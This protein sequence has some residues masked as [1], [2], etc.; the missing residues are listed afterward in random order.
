MHT[1]SLSREYVFNNNL[2]PVAPEPY[3]YFLKHAN[4]NRLPSDLTQ[5]FT[6]LPALCFVLKQP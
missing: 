5:V 4:Y 1:P 6:D 2:S 3:V